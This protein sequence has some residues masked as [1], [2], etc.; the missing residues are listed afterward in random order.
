MVVIKAQF[1]S[2]IQTS[3]VA[4]RV[5]HSRCRFAPLIQSDRKYTLQSATGALMEELFSTLAK[6]LRCIQIIESGA[7]DPHFGSCPTEI[8]SFCMNYSNLCVPFVRLRSPRDLASVFK[9][10]FR[11]NSKS[12]KPTFLDH[13][14]SLAGSNSSK[15]KILDWNSNSK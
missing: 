13:I 8:S 9:R 1:S 4:Y 15:Q 6:K 2:A 3:S 5:A 7:R 14:F 11:R 10:F 12:E